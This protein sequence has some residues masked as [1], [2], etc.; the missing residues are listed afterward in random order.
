MLWTGLSG[1]LNACL[2]ELAGREGIDLMVSYQLPNADAPYDRSQ[3]TWI[4]NQFAWRTESD[5]KALS[6]RLHEFDPDVLV[7]A[8]WHIGWHRRLARERRGRSWRVM[9]MDNPWRGTLKQWVGIATAA[10]YLR[11]IADMAW[12]PGERQAAFARRLGFKERQI[13]RGSFSCD[14]KP[15]AEQYNRRLATGRQLPKAF[16]FVGR[17][18]A[19][20]GIGALSRAYALYRERTD[21]P[22]P[23]ICCG[24]GPQSTQLEGRPGIEVKG[25]VQPDDMAAVMASAGCLILPSAFEPWAL[26]IHEAAS[27]GMIILASEA[28]GA[29]VHL[30]QPGYNGFVF[31]HRD[32]ESLAGLMMRVTA[33]TSEQRDAMSHASFELSKQYSPQRW[34]DTLIHSYE[35]RSG[36]MQWN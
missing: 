3:F 4:Q 9:I 18:V 17:F 13:L 28:V 27:A 31:D 32:T 34:A 12:L 36:A 21:N 29:A 30:V 6:S 26:V 24:A 8:G 33:Q 35:N 20:K 1:Y 10:I 2:K 11:P 15:F 14:Q 19:E 22:W 23:L 5:L 7:M 16:L 25:F